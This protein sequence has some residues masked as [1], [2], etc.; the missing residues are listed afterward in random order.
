[1]AYFGD[2]LDVWRAIGDRPHTAT[3]LANLGEALRAEGDLDRALAVA[4]EGLARSREVG[5][6]QS[7]ATALFILG[8]LAQHHGHDPRAA[9][10]LVEGL[11]LYR[12]VGDRLGVAWCIEALAGPA[13]QPANRNW[14]QRSA[15]RPSRSGST[16]GCP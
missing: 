10:L 6:K 13:P 9:D 8:S 11:L 3:V 7:A 14:R 1:V 15:A 16:W 2:S 4:G 5:D 12:Q